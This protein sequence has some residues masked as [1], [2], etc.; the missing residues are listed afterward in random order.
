MSAYGLSLF[1]QAFLNNFSTLL[2]NSSSIEQMLHVSPQEAYP[3]PSATKYGLIWNWVD[4]GGRRLVG[5]QG[6]L[7]GATNLMLANEKRNLGAILLTTGDISTA[8]N[9]TIEAGPTMISI[10]TQLF[11]CFE[12]NQNMASNQYA[13]SLFIW[14]MTGFLSF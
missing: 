8:T 2:R 7:I 11:D 3:H 6:S 13:G 12:T 9:H 4:I 14:L 1:L 5:H 10:M